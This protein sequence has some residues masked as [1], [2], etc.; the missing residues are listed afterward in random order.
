MGLVGLLLSGACDSDGAKDEPS[1]TVTVYCSVDSAFARPILADF[2]SR[3]GITAHPVFDT[4]AGK[5]TGLVNRLLAE[6]HGPR[7]DVWWSSEIF[8][9]MQ[10]AAEGA[11]TPYRPDSARDIPEGYR[12]PDGLWTAFGLRGRVIAYD[13]GRTRLDDLPTRWAD[14]THVKYKGSFQ[15]AD[16]RFG[17]TRGHMATLL[18]LWGR[19]AVTE[20]CRG[21]VANGARVAGGNAQ[22][23]T[24]LVRGRVDF[25]ATDT[26]DVIVAQRRGDSVA[27]HYPNL[28][29]PD[30][31]R[32]VPGTLWIP[33]SLALVK[34]AP[35]PEPGRRLIEYLASAEIERRLHESDSRNYPVRSG[36]RDE[37]GVAV[38]SE[39][40]IDYAAAAARLTE[41]DALMQDVLLR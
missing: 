8:G 12:S 9:T 2:E 14:L 15:M 17:T 5:T 10:L 39:A 4:E 31:S 36:L 25:V 1:R 24:A 34:G 40:K 37:L 41:S 38:P 29:S 16:P 18:S 23:V 19:D 26:D 35:H 13:P 22:A 33:C 20:F 3:T 11:L 28:D 7:A 21:L 30:G 32:R 6:R 27:M